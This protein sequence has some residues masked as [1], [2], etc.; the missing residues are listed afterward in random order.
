MS[1]HDIF[2]SYSSLDSEFVDGLV[3]KLRSKGVSL[4]FDKSEIKPGNYL[5]DRIN[6]AIDNV[7]YLLAVIS[8]NSLNSEWVRREMDAAMMREL[9]GGGDTDNLIT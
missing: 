1:L 3:S 4:W 8:H 7:D 6:S 9:D 2:I 5:R